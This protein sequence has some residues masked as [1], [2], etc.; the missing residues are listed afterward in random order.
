MTHA[1]Y[2]RIRVRRSTARSLGLGREPGAARR[3]VDMADIPADAAAVGGFQRGDA[4]TCGHGI[5]AVSARIE[6]R[7]LDGRGEGERIELRPQIAA[8]AIG[9]D[10]GKHASLDLGITDEPRGSLAQ[11]MR[12]QASSAPG[13]PPPTEG[14][15]EIV[16][17]HRSVHRESCRQ[18][19]MRPARQAI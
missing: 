8:R 19:R 2:A 9:L 12:K 3:V 1:S 16:G 6:L 15:V 18:G 14:R 10:Q 5:E 7:H 13:S 11:H 17:S 4:R